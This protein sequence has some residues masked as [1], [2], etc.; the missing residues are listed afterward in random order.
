MVDLSHLKYDT[1]Y[2]TISPKEAEFYLNKQNFERNRPIRQSVVKRY[3]QCMLDGTFLNATS[4]AFAQIGNRL[5]LVNGQHRLAAVVT[6]KKSLDFVTTIYTLQNENELLLLYSAIDIG[7]DRTLGDS[8]KAHGVADEIRVSVLEASR[9][10][11]AARLLVAGLTSTIGT[12]R[13]KLMS[14]AYADDITRARSW[15]KEGRAYFDCVRGCPRYMGNVM[16]RAPLVASGIW[17]F[18]HQPAKAQEFWFEVSHLAS[19][20]PD[21]PRR[22]LHNTF[23]D[24]LLTNNHGVGDD[25]PR[26]TPH[27]VRLTMSAWNAHFSGRSLKSLK[28]SGIDSSFSGCK[29]LPTK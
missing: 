3:A 18:R 24:V 10:A 14:R 17:T 15:A 6:S 27:L 29:K 11:V 28:P 7:I 22:R 26:T 1:T 16:K 25:T 13:H 2:E 19:V 9:L 21:D 5:V 23:V 12:S 8:I 4:L 20:T